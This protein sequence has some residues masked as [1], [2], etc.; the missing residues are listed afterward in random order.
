MVDERYF[1][2]TVEPSVADA[3]S[4]AN[5]AAVN[6]YLFMD[7]A[8]FGTG[9]FRDGT[10]LIPHTRELF[11]NTRKQISSYKNYVKP[12]LRAL[13][14]PVFTEEAPRT[15]TNKN[16]TPI[17]SPTM[18]GGF[19]ENVDNAGTAMQ[20]F[21]EKMIGAVRRHGVSFVVMDNFPEELQPAAVEQAISTRTY[22]YVYQKF[23]WEVEGYS[24][25]KFGHIRE[26]TF[27]I[28]D[29]EEND[30][31]IKQY[32]KWTDEY[33]VVLRRNERTGVYEEHGSRLFHNLGVV[34]VIAIYSS[35]KEDL[36]EVLV[37]PPLYDLARLNHMLY[38]R[39]S[40]IRDLE[41][42]QAFSI[43]VIQADQAGDYTIS[44]Y[45]AIIIST[46][47][48]IPPQFISPNPE[49]LTA[50]RENNEALREDLFR[51]AEQSGVVG[52]ASAKSGI[53]IQWDFY[54]HESQLKKTAKLATDMEHSIA[55][56]FQLYTG[57]QFEYTVEYP[58]DFQ[59]GNVL[60]VVD[61]FKK[62]LDLG[63]PEKFKAV[64][65]EKLA[66]I[67]MSDMDP[68]RLQEVVDDINA[69]TVPTGDNNGIDTPGPVAED[70]TAA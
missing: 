26:I 38:N 67:V 58:S 57:E 41:R 43:L 27:R 47:S 6:K 24:V 32:R 35:L 22:P 48:T 64:L 31:V 33:S 25:D 17:T 7:H 54:A 34:P 52:V 59:P 37:D 10:Y 70:A 19:L 46:Q 55:T 63:I 2:D 12:I 44:P 61:T 16:G 18:W 30:D 13:V 20:D 50:L 15:L 11:Y 39:D 9:G 60:S 3:N 29:A 68:V 51:I 21:A 66:R 45:N 69:Y 14:E 62:I 28:E 4:Y 53:A 5:I 1:D 23:A 36:S 42:A 49:I 65:F 56:L 40:E 8:Y